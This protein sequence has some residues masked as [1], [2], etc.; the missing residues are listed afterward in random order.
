MN[1]TD[2]HTTTD[3]ASQTYMEEEVVQHGVILGGSNDDSLGCPA[4]LR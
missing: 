4:R 2:E 3:G 1:R